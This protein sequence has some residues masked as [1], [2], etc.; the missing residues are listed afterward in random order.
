MKYKFLHR[1]NYPHVVLDILIRQDDKRRRF[2][3]SMLMEKDDEWHPKYHATLYFFEAFTRPGDES[4][5][6]PIIKFIPELKKTKANSHPDKATRRD[7]NVFFKKYC[8]PKTWQEAGTDGWKNTLN[9]WT[10]YTALNPWI[11]QVKEG[12][13]VDPS[14]QVLDVDNEAVEGGF[15]DETVVAKEA[16][17]EAQMEEDEY[18]EQ[19]EEA[20]DEMPVDIEASNDMQV[21]SEAP[22]IP[23]YDITDKTQVDEVSTWNE[24][25]RYQ[26][27]VA[28]QTITQT[29]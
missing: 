28:M 19:R 27:V 17:N 6:N 15:E 22:Q 29:G 10:T 24:F 1:P 5:Q 4:I 16:E 12:Q 8:M 21:E 18:V 13:V 26:F 23:Y 14:N 20:E 25:A 2:L 9:G 7:A 3:I 11:K